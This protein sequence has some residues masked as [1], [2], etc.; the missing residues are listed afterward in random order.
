MYARQQPE[1]WPTG[2]SSRQ[3]NAKPAQLQ[4]LHTLLTRCE[5]VTHKAAFSLLNI[6]YSKGSLRC[7]TKNRGTVD[8][9]QAFP[10]PESPTENCQSGHLQIR[11]SIYLL[12]QCDSAALARG[13]WWACLA[14]SRAD[15]QYTCKSEDNTF[16]FTVRRNINPAM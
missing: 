4:R 14:E 16:D 15:T 5:N 3:V 9:M 11:K 1:L 6:H 8:D 2:R 13:F 12:F 10:V 7:V